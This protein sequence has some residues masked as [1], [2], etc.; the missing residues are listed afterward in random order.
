MY[1]IFMVQE[2]EC[3]MVQMQI[4]VGLKRAEQKEVE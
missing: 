4:E 3:G 1:T 2:E